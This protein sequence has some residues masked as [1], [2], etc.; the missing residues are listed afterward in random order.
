MA[1]MNSKGASPSRLV[2]PGSCNQNANPPG[3]PAKII[4]SAKPFP[5]N[6]I[7]DETAASS[8]PLP[9]FCRTLLGTS[10][11]L[12]LAWLSLLNLR[13]FFSYGPA[14]HPCRL[15]PA[16]PRVSVVD[17]DGTERKGPYP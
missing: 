10:L 1:K 16:M 13:D 15:Q 6:E 8:Q 17:Q 2:P 14:L 11:L 7:I 3:P 4:S 5:Y 12:P 9:A